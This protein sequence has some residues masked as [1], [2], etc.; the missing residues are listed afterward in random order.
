MMQIDPEKQQ[1]TLKSQES[2]T[3][4]QLAQLKL[5]QQNYDRIS[6]LAEAGVV[7]KQDLDNATA[8]DAAQAQLQS[9]GAQVNEQT[10]Q[11]HYYRVVAPAPESSAM[12]PFG[13]GT[14]C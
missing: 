9:L 1:A 7:S 2:A 3:A 12:F 5:A 11:L 6:G 8:L 14:A 4:A 10:V 13:S